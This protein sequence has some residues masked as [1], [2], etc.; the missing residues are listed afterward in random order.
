MAGNP[1]GVEGCVS[2]ERQ[3]SMSRCARIEKAS[4]AAGCLA[5]AASGGMTCIGTAADSVDGVVQQAL[6][7]SKRGR[8]LSAL[9]LRQ[10]RALVGVIECFLLGGEDPGTLRGCG[11]LRSGEGGS[12][13]G[14]LAVEGGN[15]RIP[16]SCR[17]RGLNAP[18]GT[19]DAERDDREDPWPFDDP[20]E[21]GGDHSLPAKRWSTIR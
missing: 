18:G 1:A 12:V 6:S 2:V 4:E 11:G 14:P 21:N 7:I 5:V 3:F 17:H 19:P 8:S 15:G 16:R 13:S 9:L 20:R 10:F